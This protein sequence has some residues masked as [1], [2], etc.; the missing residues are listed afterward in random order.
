M[1][2]VSSP[3][4]IN[5]AFVK[6]QNKPLQQEE[7]SLP[8]TAKA[9]YNPAQT[10]QR[11]T[12]PTLSLH[13]AISPSYTLNVLLCQDVATGKKQPLSERHYPVLEFW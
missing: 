5:T 9:D 10:F 4:Q 13:T 12:L 1:E 6:K 3:K 8:I 11:E 2:I 7:T